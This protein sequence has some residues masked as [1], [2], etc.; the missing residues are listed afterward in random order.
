MTTLWLDII[1]R[2][3]LISFQRQCYN[4]SPVCNLPT[5]RS[6]LKVS[7]Q[8]HLTSKWLTSLRPQL[9]SAGSHPTATGSTFCSSTIVTEPSSNQVAT[10]ASYQVT[11]SYCITIIIFITSLIQG[12]SLSSP[13]FCAC[14]LVC[15]VMEYLDFLNDLFCSLWDR[16]HRKSSFSDLPD[17]HPVF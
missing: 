4:A 5:C 8:C 9:L 6:V 10:D 7:Q 14:K 12:Q 11:T 16:N 2:S 13:K 1:M 17:F 15:N 3:F